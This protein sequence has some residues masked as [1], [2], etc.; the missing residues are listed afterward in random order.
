MVKIG[1]PAILFL[2]V[3]TWSTMTAQNPERPK[4][5]IRV[6]PIGLLP[7]YKVQLVSG[8]D[9]GGGTIWKDGGP[10]IEFNCCGHFGVEADGIDKREVVWRKEQ[11]L[12]G[13]PVICVYT[14]SKRL[15][16]SIPRQNV[17]FEGTI[18]S[19]EDLADMLLMVLT[20]GSQGYPVEPGVVVRA[21]Q[22]PR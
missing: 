12:N 7:G 6:S 19:Q 21:P 10:K 11:V 13:Q 5:D 3:A 14:K 18:R 4:G 22:P 15:I 8:I 1:I 9:T 16:V 20:Y 2:L 17:N